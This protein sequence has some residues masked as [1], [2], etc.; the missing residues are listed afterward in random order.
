VKKE[1]IVSFV[2]STDISLRE[3]RPNF[4]FSNVSIAR[5]EFPE[6]GYSMKL[7]MR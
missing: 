1:R 2:L 7:T 3:R 5:E 6:L 4:L